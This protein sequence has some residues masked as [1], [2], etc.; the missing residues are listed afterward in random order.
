VQLEI[1]HQG[2]R[3]A[4]VGHAHE[5]PVDAGNHRWVDGVPQELG[6]RAAQAHTALRAPC[7]AKRCTECH[8]IEERHGP[9]LGVPCDESRS[10][11]LRA[12]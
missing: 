10:A 12:L 8:E 9:T 11:R 6:A 7:A 5:Q 1:E 2:A 4:L 3:C